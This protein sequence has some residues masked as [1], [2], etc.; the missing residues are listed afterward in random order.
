MY[1]Y[2]KM[3]NYYRKPT[4]G[5]YIIYIMYIRI[6]YALLKLTNVFIFRAI[7]SRYTSHRNGIY[8]IRAILD[9]NAI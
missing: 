6:K 1:T 8:L 5:A 4:V 9:R 3:Y 7:V 2:I